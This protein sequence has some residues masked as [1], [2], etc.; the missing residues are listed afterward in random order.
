MA[1]INTPLQ[2]KEPRDSTDERPA[3]EN[4]ELAFIIRESISSPNIMS[5][6]N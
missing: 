4:A 3:D 2:R 1:D 6:K 5:G